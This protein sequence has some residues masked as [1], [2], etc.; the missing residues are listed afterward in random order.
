MNHELS[1]ESVRRSERGGKYVLGS[2]LKYNG[3]TINTD[4][5]IGATGEISSLTAVAWRMGLANQNR[6]YRHIVAQFGCKD[7]TKVCETLERPVYI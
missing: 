3:E 6:V 5:Y 7:R 4:G 2:Y 1:G